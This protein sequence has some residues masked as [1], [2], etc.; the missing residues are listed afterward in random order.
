MP[1]LGPLAK[2]IAVHFGGW[3]ML[4]SP[5]RIRVYRACGI[6]IGQSTMVGSEIRFIS[7]RNLT[8]G[9]R[10][11]IGAQTYFE[12]HEHVTLEDDVWVAARTI[13]ATATHDV[14]ES[15]H[16][17][18]A[19]KAAPIAVG[20]GTWIGMACTVLPGVSIGSGCVIAAGSVVT[21]NCEPNGLYAGV[22]AVRKRDL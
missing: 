10:C 18:G 7:C 17:A 21:S 19:W 8:I 3:F 22:P 4:R 6:R 5:V 15:A 13:F 16:R 9:E 11:Y 12:N 2:L 20:R 14:G 1:I